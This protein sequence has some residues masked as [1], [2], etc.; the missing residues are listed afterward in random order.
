MQ[1]NFFV[2]TAG[3]DSFL[4]AWLQK[5][6]TVTQEA[7]KDS[8]DEVTN[9]LPLTENELEIEMKARCEEICE[10][11]S[12][13]TAESEYGISTSELETMSQQLS[14]YSDLLFEQCRRE[15]IMS[16]KNFEELA[17]VVMCDNTE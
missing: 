6:L 15:N 12:L 7:T 8:L 1:C 9:L 11:C 13:Q 17:D 16:L 10:K 3:Y 5:M 14:V 4:R 2:C